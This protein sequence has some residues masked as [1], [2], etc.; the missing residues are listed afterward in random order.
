MSNSSPASTYLLCIVVLNITFLPTVEEVGEN[1][2]FLSFD[3]IRTDDF[4]IDDSLSLFVDVTAV[5]GSAVG[6]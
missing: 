4:L 2:E 6:T 5:S 1:E 3:V